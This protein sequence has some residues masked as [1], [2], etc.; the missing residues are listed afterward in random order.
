MR[1]RT[2][3][4]VAIVLALGCGTTATAQLRTTEPSKSV[5]LQ[6]LVTDKGI[7]IAKWVSSVTH[8]GM[9]VLA[10][11]IPRGDYVSIN[12][13]N[14]SRR[15]HVITV[16][17]KKTRPIKPGGK[18]HLFTQAVTRGTFPYGSSGD[19]RKTFRGVLIVA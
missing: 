8:D 17:G 19:R 3:V 10:G 2:A 5:L 16:M 13:L 12:V 7:V 1:S 14:R 4:L 15:T 9:L 11:P 6:V 18:A